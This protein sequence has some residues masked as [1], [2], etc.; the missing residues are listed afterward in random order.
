M[1]SR[2]SARIYRGVLMPSA[3]DWELSSLRALSEG[4]AF[5][6]WLFNINLCHQVIEQWVLSIR[7]LS[8]VYHRVD[9]VQY[10]I[11]KCQSTEN[12]LCP[13]DDC[14]LPSLHS[15]STA[16]DDCPT[17]ICAIRWLS[18]E[19]CLLGGCPMS[20]TGCPLS[21]RWFRNVNLQRMFNVQ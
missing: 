1:E 2:G 8:N 10:I 9:N 17:S 19:Y 18:N 11:S 21:N 4:I 16:L 15:Q 20:I 6:G 12:V 13:I 14:E 7:W 3:D 5:T